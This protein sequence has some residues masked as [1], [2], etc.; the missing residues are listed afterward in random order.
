[1]LE[2]EPNPKQML[3]V[4]LGASSF[5]NAPTFLGGDAFYHSAA[6]FRAYLYNPNP[7]GLG[8]P[9]QNVRWLFDDSKGPSDQLQ[10]IRYFLADRSADLARIGLQPQDLIVCYVGHGLFSGANQQE[11]CFAVRATDE[12]S[13]GPTSIR[14]AD[15]ASVIQ[16][17]AKFLRRFLIFDCCFSGAAQAYFQAGLLEAARRKL[18][19]EFVPRTGTAL[20]CSASAHDV[21]FAPQG[22]PHTMFSDA[23]LSAL[24]VGHSYY[25]PR[26]SLSDLGELVEVNIRQV[27][28]ESG[29]RPEVHSPNQREGDIAGL[30]LFPNPGHYARLPQERFEEEKRRAQEEAERAKAEQLKREEKQRR[31]K[32]EVER[33]KAEQLKRE[34]KQRRAKQEVE[35]ADA[36]RLRREQEEKQQ[37]AK[38]EAERAKAEQLKR[39]EEEKQRRAKQEVERAGAQPRTRDTQAEAHPAAQQRIKA[40][41][42]SGKATQVPFHL[43]SGT[44]LAEK[45]RLDSALGQGGFGITYLAWDLNLSRKVAVKE[46]FPNNLCTRG[47][48]GRTVQPLY[49]RTQEAFGRGLEEFV[50]EGRALA[51]F[52][53]HPGIVSVYDF[54]Q[55]NETA[56]LVMAHLEGQTLKQY[57]EEHEGKIRFLEALN[58]LTPIMDALREVHAMGML[59]RDISPDNIYLTKTGPK[60]LDFGAARYAMDAGSQNLTA[61]LKPGYAPEEQYRQSGQGPWTDVYA[62]GATFYQAITG[63][64]PP[65]ALDRLARDALIPPWHL[66]VYIPPN[67]ETA[68]LKALKVCA[69]DRFQTV[70]EFQSAICEGLRPEEPGGVNKAEERASVARTVRHEPASEAAEAGRQPTETN[71]RREGA[72]GEAERIEPQRPELKRIAS[73]KTQTEHQATAKNGA[74]RMEREKRR[75]NRKLLVWVAAMVVA[76]VVLWLYHFRL[77]RSEK[78]RSTSPGPELSGGKTVT[79]ARDS[80]PQSVKSDAAGTSEAYSP[81]VLKQTLDGR[82]DSVW[83]IAFSPDGSLLALGGSDGIELWNVTTGALK[84]TL[85]GHIDTVY[86]VAFSPGGKLLVSGGSGGIELWDLITGTVRQT[87]P[88]RSSSVA[89]SPDG[90]LLASGEADNTIR[91]W[92]VSTDAPRQTFTLH[93]ETVWS[94]AFSPDGSLL[95]SGSE[96]NTIDLWDVAT[97]KLK[98]TLGRRRHVY[99]VPINVAFSPNG[100]LL[101]SGSYVAA[102]AFSP[103]GRLL[104]SGCNLS[105][106][107]MLWKRRQ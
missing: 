101:T 89:F 5:D 77:P 22:L 67:S 15:L 62:L 95:A 51:R 44:I 92:D 59:H 19:E 84:Q 70:A 13:E 94:I 24:R 3:A 50:K 102:I 53:D 7:A 56:Y 57:L 91:L 104:A 61:V 48:D 64:K 46:Y 11:Y 69:K 81:Y 68:L 38:E 32:Q 85:I 105:P 66:Q 6:D 37:R 9:R 18:M 30:P 52:R 40:E 97:G 20:L 33:A 4:I 41:E 42:A 60:L 74:K 93:T 8:L 90:H 86:S 80:A 75:P 79:A 96:Y 73:E 21:S 54:F 25:G 12:Q 14:A 87:W 28:R 82:S 36:E 106:S 2:G 107:M 47:N 43:P 71:K 17:H 99:S 10:Q 16:S 45:Y 39:E 76:L 65:D 72:E 88:S 26:L 35:R 23:L 78:Q 34:E 98:H 49:L 63:T 55:E 83:S 58:I 29:V 1:M 31:A 103:D 100:R 27:Y